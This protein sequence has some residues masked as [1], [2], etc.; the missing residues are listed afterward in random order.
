MLFD[1]SP[2]TLREKIT[3]LDLSAKRSVLNLLGGDYQ[4]V[5][6][7]RGI[8]FDEVR[9]YQ[10][11]DDPR[12]IDWNV[13]ARMDRLFVK[14]FVEERELVVFFIFDLSPTMLTGNQDKL[15]LDVGF[16][17]LSLLGNAALYKRDRVGLAVVSDKLHHFVPPSR[18]R[19]QLRICLQT[20]HQTKLTSHNASLQ[21]V[22]PLIRLIPKGAVVFFVSD[23][24]AY[25]DQDLDKQLKKL[26]MR[27]D[28]IPVWLK[29]PLPQPSKTLF[30]DVVDPLTLKRFTLSPWA[31]K[32]YAKQLT[33]TYT[34]LE[35]LFKSLRLDYLALDTSAPVILPIR[36]FFKRRENRRQHN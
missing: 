18:K 27:Y 11:G 20:L 23:F 7:G 29:D 10:E 13:T 9:E 19:E 35:N 28:V 1:Q 4:S 5:F 17:V 6:K 31:Q 15:K 25:L 3:H 34:G 21:W 2:D 8:E 26:T 32:N 12:L 30:W 36:H 16:E 22:D 24:L 33:Q 14:K